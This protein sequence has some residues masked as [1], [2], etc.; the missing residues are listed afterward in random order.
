MFTVLTYPAL[1]LFVLAALELGDYKARSQ[2]LD[3]ADGRPEGHGHEAPWSI[4]RAAARTDK[5]HGRTADHFSI[6]GVSANGAS[7]E[8]HVPENGVRERRADERV[9]A[10]GHTRQRHANGRMF[11]WTRV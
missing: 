11:G 10:V 9:V 6:S 5:R 2:D 1:L 8:E 3:P 7:C 4:H